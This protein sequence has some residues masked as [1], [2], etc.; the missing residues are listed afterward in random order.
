[1]KKNKKSKS[2]KTPVRGYLSEI[3]GLA[4]I[5]SEI[6]GSCFRAEIVENSK[7]LIEN[8]KGIAEYDA[9]CVKINCGRLVMTVRG[10]DLCLVAMNSNGLS[11]SGSIDS[12]TY[13]N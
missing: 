9:E 13:E 7:I 4:D 12:V 11:I 6:I 8:H 2:E 1:M 10:S 3:T 5:S